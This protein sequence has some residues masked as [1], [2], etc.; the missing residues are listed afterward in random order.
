MVTESNDS[1]QE[2]QP[3]SEQG[4]DA[5][6]GADESLSIDQLESK[7]R[8]SGT[9]RRL[10]LYGAFIDIGLDK[11]AILHISKLD[12]RVNR[13]SDALSI[14]D[15]VEVWIESV[16]EQKG[17]VTVTMQEPLAVEWGDLQKGQV[18]T[19]TVTRIEKF[20]AFVDIGAEKEGLVH[21][22]ELSH[23]FVKHPSEAVKP[24]DEIQVSVLDFN[25]G[26]RRID[27]SQ[28]VLLD[29]PVSEDVADE[30]ELEE[31]EEVV[32][33]AME[34]ALREA[35]DQSNDVKA[36]SPAAAEKSA[37]KSKSASKNREQ[38]DDILSRTLKLS[39]ESGG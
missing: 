32:P 21:I 2:E 24:G 20:G 5:V 27:L 16:D 22:S 7:M 14:G 17:Q 19:G 29:L 10:E 4:V 6:S 39:Q 15:K 38:Q 36:T 23:D 28:K 31:E 30:I 12:K 34:I 13:I 8:V 3:V 18:Y 37:A 35:M 9:V 26:K 11:P 33:T 25:K 1:I